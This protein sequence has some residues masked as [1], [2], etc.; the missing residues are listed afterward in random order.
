MVWS[1]HWH[2]PHRQTI[3][4]AP[5][6]VNFLS[7]SETQASTRGPLSNDGPPLSSSSL[8][9]CQLASPLWSLFQ[10]LL[11]FFPTNNCFSHYSSNC[12]WLFQGFTTPS[13]SWKVCN[14]IS[15]MCF[16]SWRSQNLWFLHFFF[17]MVDKGKTFSSSVYEN[18]SYLRLKELILRPVNMRTVFISLK[19]PNLPPL[20]LFPRLV[21]HLSISHI[22]LYLVH[23][24]SIL[25]LLIISLVTNIFF[26]CWPVLKHYL[27]LL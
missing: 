26:L 21:M 2:Q 27:W 19:Q 4:H 14:P 20:P 13:C 25:V 5:S 11:A 15:M 8:P 17:S 6:H 1:I 7:D 22:L 16:S 3:I 24:S 12:F 23:G 9:S 18:L 10:Q